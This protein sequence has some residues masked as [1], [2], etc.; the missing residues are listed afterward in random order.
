MD[1]LRSLLVF[2]VFVSTT[3]NVCVLSRL[4][5]DYAPNC[6]WQ[7]DWSFDSLSRKVEVARKRQL[8]VVCLRQ[9]VRS[10]SAAMKLCRSHRSSQSLSWI[11]K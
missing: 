8:V 11:R 5:L 1:V 6:L 9:K 3:T 10:Q 4:D 7:L 2:V